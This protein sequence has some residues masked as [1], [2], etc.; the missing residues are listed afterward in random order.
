MPTAPNGLQVVSVMVGSV[1]L[2]FTGSSDADH[3]DMYR[4]MDGLSFGSKVNALP[5]PATPTPFSASFTDGAG[6]SIDPPVQNGNYY[7][8]AV[9]VD[10]SGNVSL[11]SNTAMS[12]VGFSTEV[13]P[14]QAT[15]ISVE[16]RGN[17]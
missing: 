5:I 6:I 4:S 17:P 14:L 1:G 13:T 8:K 11:P 10:S 7:Y 9:S 2:S 3:Y 15:L 16:Q 12:V